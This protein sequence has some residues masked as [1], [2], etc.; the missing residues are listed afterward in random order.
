[1]AFVY[2]N[3]WNLKQR[4]CPSLRIL[5]SKLLI[6]VT[7]EFLISIFLTFEFQSIDFPNDTSPIFM[8]L[9]AKKLKTQFN[10]LLQ[11]APKIILITKNDQKE[12]TYAHM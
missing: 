5:F 2:R 7:N 4:S 8:A 6:F 3:K 9:A 1:M 11:T 10:E 12:N